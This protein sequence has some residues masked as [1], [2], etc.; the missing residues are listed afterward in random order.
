M[1]RRIRSVALTAGRMPSSLKCWRFRGL[2][3]RAMIRSQRYFSFATWQI[4]D[5]VL[6]VAGDGDHEVGA[7]D[8]RALEHPQLGAVAVLD[9]VLELLLDAQVARAVA[10]DE[11]DLVALGDQLAREVEA[12]LA[13]ADDE[14]VHL[15]DG[16][17]EDACSNI[18]IA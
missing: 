16:R 1:R 17:S 12:D 13:A 9:G 14:D 11:R 8:A 15:R 7:L 18:S 6:V 2:L 10:L 5:V 3:T 4:E